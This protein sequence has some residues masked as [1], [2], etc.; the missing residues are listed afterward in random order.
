MGD[1]DRLKKYISDYLD[2]SLDPTTR[3]QFEEKLRTN[4]E[5]QKLTN[6]VQH[7]SKLLSTLP[8]HKC[9][10]DFNIR[11]RDRIH[12][13]TPISKFNIN[14]RRYSI[15]FSFVVII[16]VAIFG[17][18]GMLRDD[19]ETQTARPSNAVSVEKSVPDNEEI[20]VKTRDPQAAATDS[21]K[22]QKDPRIKYVDQ[23]K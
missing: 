1:C 22:D 2:G 17:I 18:N 9:K 19:T 23:K 3:T 13:E 7:V 14:I 10:D 21:I 12:S 16:G 20:D 11:L 15:A 8:N 4:T 6:Q 5:L